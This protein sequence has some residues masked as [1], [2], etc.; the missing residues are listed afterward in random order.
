LAASVARELISGDDFVVVPAHIFNT[1]TGEPISAEQS[2]H[3][4]MFAEPWAAHVL[5]DTGAPPGG[6]STGPFP[7][8]VKTW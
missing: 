8:D 2:P 1:R 7:G 6:W 3:R 5:G 4:P